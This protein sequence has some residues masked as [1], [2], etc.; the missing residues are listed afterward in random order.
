[1]LRNEKARLLH[2]LEIVVMRMELLRPF[3]AWSCAGC[4]WRAGYVWITGLQ[5][6][7]VRSRKGIAERRNSAVPL[8]VRCESLSGVER[9]SWF[10]LIWFGWYTHKAL[11]S[12]N[13]M[14][15]GIFLSFASCRTLC[16]ECFD[17]SQGQPIKR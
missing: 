14:E 6:L 11:A 7:C 4:S 5:H 15:W 3:R 12:K 16:N 9:S 13:L 1:M 8:E 10:G 2:T 17:M